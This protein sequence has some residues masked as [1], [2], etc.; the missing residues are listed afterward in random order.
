MKR[1]RNSI[2]P[3]ALATL[4]GLAVCGAVTIISGRREAWDLSLYFIAGIPAMCA[5]VFPLAYS[6]PVKAWR[7]AV[8]M[9][10]GQSIALLLGGGSLSL[11]PL[12]IIAMT[13]LSLPQLAVA[14][15]AANLRERRDAQSSGTYPDL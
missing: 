11:W 15:V 7:W 9:A 1:D 3:F 2:L 14:I 10:L 4:A 5:L 13:V 8:G 12:A 6:F